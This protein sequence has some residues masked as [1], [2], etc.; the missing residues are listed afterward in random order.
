MR[1]IFLLVLGLLVCIATGLVVLAV[2]RRRVEAALPRCGNCGYNLT[3]SPSNR[4][5]ECG[6]LFIDA[7]VITREPTPPPSRHMIRVVLLLLVGF[8]MLGVLGMV[9]M[10]WRARAAR[11]QAVTAR[12]AAIQ[13]GRQATSTAPA[14]EVRPA[15][16]TP[17]TP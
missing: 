10:G 15:D 13:A 9:A 5:P 2:S 11:T 6:M 8:T 16:P 12:Q 17:Q 3:G 14:T 7:G 1:I 4:C